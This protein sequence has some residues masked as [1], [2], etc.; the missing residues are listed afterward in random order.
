MAERQ[1]AVL[2]LLVLGD[3][4]GGVLGDIGEENHEECHGEDGQRSVHQ[5]EYLTDLSLCDLGDQQTRED[6]DEG[7]HQRIERTADLN[8]LVTLVAAAREFVE[9][10]VHDDVQHTHREACDERA[11]K[12]DAERT[13]ESRNGLDRN[14]DETDGDGDQRRLL[15]AHVLEHVARGDTHHGIGDEVGEHAERTHPV[16]HAEL[17]L[18]HVAHRRRQVGHERDHSEQ[19]NHHDDRQYVTVL[20]FCFHQRF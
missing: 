19:Q 11:Q 12:V 1:R 10:G 5:R 13:D 7:T 14:A 15:V 18:Q 20:F 4:L 8:E 9:H 17:V 2:R 3:S 16:G 6:D